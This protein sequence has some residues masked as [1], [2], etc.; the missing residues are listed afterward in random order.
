[1]NTKRSTEK[2]EC[3]VLRVYVTAAHLKIA[4]CVEILFPTL[5]PMGPL[6]PFRPRTPDW[7]ICRTRTSRLCG[8]VQTADD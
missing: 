7:T 4:L 8:H 1:M 3:F 2:G 5:G 6:A